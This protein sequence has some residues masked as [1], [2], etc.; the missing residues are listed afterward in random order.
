MYFLQEEKEDFLS[1]AQ[2]NSERPEEVDEEK[3]KRL[4]ERQDEEKRER[5]SKLNSWKARRKL[6]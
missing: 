3:Q 1:K 6:I 4:Q 2:A 5:L